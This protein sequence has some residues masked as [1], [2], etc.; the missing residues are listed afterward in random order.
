[1]Q[2]EDLS[3]KLKID[4]VSL[5]RPF[6]RDLRALVRT[7]KKSRTRAFLF[8]SGSYPAAVK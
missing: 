8:H 2:A 7:V 4:L 6:E 3:K 5:T 1:L